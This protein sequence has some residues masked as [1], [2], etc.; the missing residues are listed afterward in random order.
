[1]QSKNINV[2]DRRAMISY[3][4]GEACKYDCL[5]CYNQENPEVDR[6]ESLDEIIKKL[7]S[8]SDY[9]DIISA[10]CE[11]ELFLYPKGALEY[12]DAVSKLGKVVSIVTKAPLSRK[13]IKKLNLIDKELKKKGNYLAMEVSFISGKERPEIENKTPTVERRIKNMVDLKNVGI[14]TV[15]FIRPILPDEIVSVE[16]IYPFIDKTKDLVDVYALG[17][18]YFNENIMEKMKLK[19][20]G[21]DFFNNVEDDINVDFFKKNLWYKYVNFN[22]KS[23]ICDYIKKYGKFVYDSS[24]EAILH[25]KRK[26][27]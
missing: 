20:L 16:E 5:Y 8:K 2:Y 4:L 13:T 15:P 9:F 19:N 22:K 10:G 6:F 24:T 23:K 25:F 14:Y 3:D 18:F 27:L 17:D 1:M 26:N 11:Q 12:V 21:N 7:K